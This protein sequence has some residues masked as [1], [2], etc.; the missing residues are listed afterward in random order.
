MQLGSPA[1]LAAAARAVD[2]SE[3]Y[4]R[5]ARGWRWPL[6][7]A[8]LDTTDAHY[9]I[10]DLHEGRCR[11]AHEVDRRGFEQAPFRLSADVAEWHRVLAGG[12]DPMRCILLRDL[13]FAGERLTALRYLPAAKAL[14][15]AMGT[16]DTEVPVP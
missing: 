9:G 3:E 10:L 14:L 11:G 16:V 6:G 8:F 5:A 15:E 7:L 13:E 2:A 4:R 1:W 12:A